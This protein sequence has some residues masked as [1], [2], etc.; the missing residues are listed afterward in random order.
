MRR[1]IFVCFFA[2]LFISPSNGI[3]YFDDFGSYDNP[4]S[5]NPPASGLYASYWSSDES[6]ETN[7]RAWHIV[8]DPAYAPTFGNFANSFGAVGQ[9]IHWLAFTVDTPVPITEVNLEF[10]YLVQSN[11]TFRIYVS[12]VDEYTNL[13]QVSFAFIK[14]SN[15]GEIQDST[16]L[17]DLM[18]F[19]TSGAS[20][21]VIRFESDISDVGQSH[22]RLDNFNLEVI[23]EPVTILLFGLGGILLRR[24]KN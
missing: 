23:P 1:L 8:D 5:M 24:R 13:N 20:H 16:G 4:G 3:V 6:Y 15:N 9:Q 12:S 17:I 7:Q 11:A 10:D 21:L 19:L 18:P 2:L 22:I 14:R